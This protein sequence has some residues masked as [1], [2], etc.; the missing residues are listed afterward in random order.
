MRLLS[1]VLLNWQEARTPVSYHKNQGNGY[2]PY[3][4]MYWEGTYLVNP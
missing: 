2:N 1:Y 3:G 4:M